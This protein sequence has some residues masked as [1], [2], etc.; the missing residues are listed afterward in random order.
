MSGNNLI[1]VFIKINILILCA[2]TLQAVG[3]YG[4]PLFPVL[5]IF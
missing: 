4:P 3:D 2:V 5:C 1:I